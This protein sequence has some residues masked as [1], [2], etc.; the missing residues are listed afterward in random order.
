MDL[1]EELAAV[2]ACV[3]ELP[4]KN[5]ELLSRT[6]SNI[7]ALVRALAGGHAAQTLEGIYCECFPKPL[8][9]IDRDSSNRFVASLQHFGNLSRVWLECPAAEFAP[10][11]LL[12][13]VKTL[14]LGKYRD[15]G[16]VCCVAAFASSRR[17]QCVWLPM[18]SVISIRSPS[19]R[20]IRIT[21]AD[22]VDLPLD[23]AYD[24]GLPS[25]RVFTVD[26]LVPIAFDSVDDARETGTELAARLSRLPNLNV[27]IGAIKEVRDFDAF[28][29]MSLLTPAM[30]RDTQSIQRVLAIDFPATRLRDL[31]KVSPNLK[32]RWGGPLHSYIASLTVSSARYRSSFH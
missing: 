24:G 31:P 8:R 20:K 16:P 13:C 15:K 2:G 32:G 6:P 22:L 7:E 27:D 9:S 12:P 30:W 18:D 21:Q 10:L 4:L 19:L 29:E 14:N 23:S 25:L 28:M 17:A 3:R 5:L 11:A 1:Q 26:E